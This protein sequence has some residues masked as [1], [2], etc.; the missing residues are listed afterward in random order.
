MTGK[1]H[2]AI[3]ITAGLALS[4]GKPT[5][6]Q[7]SIMLASAL[8]SLAPD[9]DHPKAKLNQQLLLHKNK[10][11]RV[12]FYLSLAAIFTYFYFSTG[13]LVFALLSVMTFFISISSHRGFTHS[14]IGYL[15]ATHIVKLITIEYNLL[16]IHFGFSLGYLSHLIGDFFTV[17]GIKLFYPLNINVTS[18]IMIRTDNSF[19]SIIMTLLSLYSIGFLLKSLNFVY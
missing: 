18:P 15:I 16:H 13:K 19:E 6:I 5:E 11:Y 9:L 1:T 3:G 12:I 8:G 7:L 2:M 4:A 10:L 14:I 17:K